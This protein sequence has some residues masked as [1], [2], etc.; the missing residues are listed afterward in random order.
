MADKS[1]SVS[2]SDGLKSDISMI[3]I[4]NNYE[5]ELTE[6]GEESTDEKMTKRTYG[7]GRRRGRRRGRGRGRP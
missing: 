5:T 4:N 3:N 1:D 7:R 2:L 6:I